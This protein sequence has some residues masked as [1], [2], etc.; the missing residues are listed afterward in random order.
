M[1]FH[2]L[3]LSLSDVT[4]SGITDL[5]TSQFPFFLAFTIPGLGKGSS[6]L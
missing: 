1:S 6:E 3:N 4:K 2:F 5:W